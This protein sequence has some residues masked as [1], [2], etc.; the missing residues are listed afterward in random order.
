MTNCFLASWSDLTEIENQEYIDYDS[1][2][3][4]DDDYLLLE[5]FLGEEITND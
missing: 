3:N 1:L 4:S 5:S 2:I